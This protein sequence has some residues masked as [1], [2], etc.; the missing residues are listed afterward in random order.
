MYLLLLRVES[1]LSQHFVLSRMYLHRFQQC[2]I[3]DI[4]GSDLKHVSNTELNVWTGFIISWKEC[5]VPL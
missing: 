5:V 1:R 2:M 3:K 4:F